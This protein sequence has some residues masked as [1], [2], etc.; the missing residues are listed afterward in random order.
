MNSQL[1][2]L[3]A[4]FLYVETSHSP[5]HIAALQILEVPRDKRHV[6]FRE[7]QQHVARRA[8]SLEF[9]T[10]RLVSRTF[11]LDHPHWETVDSL[12]IDHH[13]RRIVLPKPG[14]IEQLEDAVARLHEAPLDRSK[15][16]W[17][18]YVIEGV[19]ENKVA[20]YTKMHHA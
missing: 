6:F 16:L 1:N 10:R 11:G 4:T 19:E 20:W 17:Q 7:M 2:L 5:M 3:D 15:P 9:T 8:P 18:F 12:D 13:V 14:S